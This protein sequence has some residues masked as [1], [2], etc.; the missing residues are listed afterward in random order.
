MLTFEGYNGAQLVRRWLICQRGEQLLQL[1]SHMREIYVFGPFLVKDGRRECKRYVVLFTYLSSHA[2]HLEMLD[3]MTN[4][5]FINALRIF[6]PIRGPVSSLHPNRGPNF[7]GAD[8]ELKR[9]GGTVW[10]SICC[11][12]T[13]P[14]EQTMPIQVQCAGGQSYGRKLGAHDQNSENVMRGVLIEKR[15][16]RL[17]SSG[18]RALLNECI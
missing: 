3:D 6:L 16:N 15:S 7:I 9:G 2:V 5:S 12:L 13:V 1:H 17:D 8:N 4:D 18:L 11:S 10:N 14:P